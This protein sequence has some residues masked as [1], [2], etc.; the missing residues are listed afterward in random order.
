MRPIQKQSGEIKLNREN[1]EYGCFVPF[2][3][4]E[5]NKTTG[6]YPSRGAK[7]TK[8]PDCTFRTPRKQQN[9]RIAPFAGRESSKT[10]GLHL[11]HGA[12]AT[13]QRDCTFRAARKPEK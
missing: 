10:A 3:R 12:K 2:A 6:L 7:V 8:Q 11:S 1:P 13:K 9:N 5:S 4:R